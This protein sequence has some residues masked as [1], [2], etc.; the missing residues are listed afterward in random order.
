MSNKELLFPVVRDVTLTIV[1]VASILTGLFVFSGIWPPMVVIE[2]GSMQHSAEE[3]S[4]GVIDAGDL[5]LIRADEKVDRIV[6]WVEGRETGYKRYG[7]NGDV[8]VFRK[9]GLNGSTPVI[10]R[11]LV[12]IDI[13]QTTN[14]SFD[15]PSMGLYDVQELVLEDLPTY[16]NGSRELI[17]LRIDLRLILGNFNGVKTPHGGFITKGDS[18]PHVDQISL[19]MRGTPELTTRRVEPILLEWVVGVSRGE[20]PWFGVLKLMFSDESANV[21]ANSVHNLLISIGLIVALPTLI[22]LVLITARR[23]VRSR[24]EGRAEQRVGG[25][26]AGGGEAGDGEA[27]EGEAGEGEAGPGPREGPGPE[28]PGEVIADGTPPPTP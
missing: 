14:D 28:A 12:W 27:G 2:S 16:H 18:N 26:E 20:I 9:N 5:T 24:G 19:Y 17:D 8:I 1:V 4:V 13:N 15:V 7:D 22:D 21:P 25:G 10:H 23:K 3:S 11:A 6:T